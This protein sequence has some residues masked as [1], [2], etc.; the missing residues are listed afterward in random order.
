MSAPAVGC[1]PFE[2]TLSPH[3]VSASIPKVRAIDW[4]V[5]PVLTLYLQRSTV[6]ST[7]SLVLPC[8]SNVP[9]LDTARKQILRSYPPKFT[10][11]VHMKVADAALRVAASD[12]LRRISV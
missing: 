8:L 11:G 10:P 9:P 7:Q 1:V 4:N 2:F 6:M 5:S 3:N 12:I